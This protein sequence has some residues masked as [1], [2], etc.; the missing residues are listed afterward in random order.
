MQFDKIEIKK[1][2]KVSK[3]WL[4]TLTIPNNCGCQLGRRVLLFEQE[5]E[6]TEE[7]ITIRL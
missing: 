7:E 6:P 1:K 4:I 5:E 2:R 3:G